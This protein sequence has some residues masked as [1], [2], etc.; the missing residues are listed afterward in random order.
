VR[1]DSI[2]V[3]GMGEEDPIADNATKAGQSLNRRV[4]IKV[5]KN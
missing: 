3:K 5:I 2:V 4:E 1:A